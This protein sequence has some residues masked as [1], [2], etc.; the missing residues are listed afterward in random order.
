MPK[1]E[2]NINTLKHLPKL[3]KERI[4]FAVIWRWASLGMSAKEF[5]ARVKIAR[6]ELGL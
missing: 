5:R 1:N 2:V 6:K 4:L 3:D